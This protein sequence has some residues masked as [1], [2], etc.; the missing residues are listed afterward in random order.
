MSEGSDQTGWREYLALY[1]NLFGVGGGIV[2]VAFFLFWLFGVVSGAVLIPALSVGVTL[3]SVWLMG[4]V[5]VRNRDPLQS[6]GS[7]GHNQKLIEAAS[8]K[9]LQAIPEK[10]KPKL[11]FEIDERDIS[12]VRVGNGNREICRIHLELKLRCIKE[13]D[14]P[15]AVKSFHASLHH[16][17]EDGS[18]KTIINQEDT[19]FSRKLPNLDILPADEMWTI[20]EPDSGFR[21][22]QFVTEISRRLQASLSP[23]HF[24]RVTMN[25]VGQG[26]LAQNVFV[27]DWTQP[28]SR[29]SLTRPE[30]LPPETQN[31]INALKRRLNSADQQI[32]TIG[33][34]YQQFEALIAL[35]KKHRDAIA[36]R[37][38]VTDCERGDLTLQP[39][40]VSSHPRVMLSLWITNKSLLEVAISNDL[41]GSIEFE[42]TELRES[43]KIVNPI[44]SLETGDRQCLTI[45]QRLSDS[46]V[47]MLLRSQHSTRP[48]YF[49]FENLIL[50]IIGGKRSPDLKATQLKIEK[51][52][53]ALAFPV[54]P[55]V[56]L[57]RVRA[58][59]E[60]RG[61]CFELH[62]LL[63]IAEDQE[64][65]LPIK[66]IES[67]RDRSSD[68]L[69]KVYEDEGAKHL[70]QEITHSEPIPE[71][72]S[73]QR[74]WL[75]GCL[76][77]LGAMLEEEAG[78]Y[79]R[80]LQHPLT[81]QH[82]S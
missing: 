66:Q 80:N 79:V 55:L 9:T 38:T 6:L 73:F 78:Q 67:W 61:A 35:A 48:L 11:T 2:S 71:S 24:L 65:A 47:S 8:P 68:T 10:P 7:L 45:E 16:L 57:Q 53:K 14:G 77:V 42:G 36:D 22:Y 62:E 44:T 50:N 69:K 43:K 60:V 29:I 37:V 31:E 32:E 34:Y 33:Q 72:A 18:E 25:A 74:G 51:H 15:I 17:Q 70:W 19:Q 5:F 20:R 21:V 4:H 41:A 54:S 64:Q 63:R 49:N 56:R 82:I 40:E 58:L 3:F 12:Q 39:R 81:E 26:P 28:G 75:S 59:S 46:D 30:K 13:V 76:V 1:A 52:H 27:K 23:E